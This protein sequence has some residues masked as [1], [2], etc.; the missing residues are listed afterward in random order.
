VRSWL[1]W[2]TRPGSCD[3]YARLTGA[4]LIVVA[5][6]LTGWIFY[7]GAALPNAGPVQDWGTGWAGIGTWQLTWIGL[8]IFEVAGLAS[9]GYLLRCSH[10]Q[11]RTAALLAA[12]IFVIDGWFDMLTAASRSD[13]ATSIAML[14]VA[15]L[16]TAVFLALIARKAREFETAS[17]EAS[18]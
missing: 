8:D 2:L 4:V 16:P 11:T 10:R 12:P 17:A 9:T 1:K 7:L 13:L 5:L 14:A 18:S 3:R 15:E 6:G